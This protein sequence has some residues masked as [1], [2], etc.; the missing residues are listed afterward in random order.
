MNLKTFFGNTGFKNSKIFLRKSQGDLAKFLVGS[1]KGQSKPVQWFINIFEKFGWTFKE[2]TKKA[3]II[4]WNTLK[5]F[6]K[7]EFECLHHENIINSKIKNLLKASL[8]LEK[9]SMNSSLCLTN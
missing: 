3:M 5:P 1:K 2:T 9:V 6:K 4:F 8:R 7:G